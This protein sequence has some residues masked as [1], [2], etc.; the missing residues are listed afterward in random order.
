MSICLDKFR[1]RASYSLKGPA[2]STKTSEGRNC[3]LY[4]LNLSLN[5]TNKALKEIMTKSGTVKHVCILATLDNAGRRRAFVDM[6]TPEEAR[7]VIH[8]LHGEK[9]EGYELNVS[10]AF[11]QRSG[12]PGVSLDK[13]PTPNIYDQRRAVAQAV[14]RLVNSRKIQEHSL[15]R[16]SKNFF[17]LPTSQGAS[18]NYLSCFTASTSNSNVEDLP[19]AVLSGVNNKNHLQRLSTH[20]EHRK[21]MYESIIPSSNLFEV[22][23]HNNMVQMIPSKYSGHAEI[24]ILLVSNLSP[25]ACIDSDDLFK[26]FTNKGVENLKF[27]DLDI[28]FQSGMSLG[29]GVLGFDSVPDFQKAYELLSKKELILDGVKIQCENYISKQNDRARDKF[30]KNPI[31]TFKDIT[32]LNSKSNTPCSSLIASKNSY[33]TTSFPNGTSTS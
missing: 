5:M 10:Y 28:D 25:V 9:I 6:S 14:P 4:V 3:N 33:S 12:G 13:S 15:K 24:P 22:S 2:K 17:S 7:Q 1:Q 8:R 29:R 23:C 32:L 31:E 26:F 19:A 27:A 20:P 21:P 11:I 18:K 16:V 30:S